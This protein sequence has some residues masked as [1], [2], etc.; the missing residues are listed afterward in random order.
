MHGAARPEQAANPPKA[1]AATAGW[2]WI[3]ARAQGETRWM[4]GIGRSDMLGRADA[5]IE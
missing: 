1:S 3:E 2:V 5:V 4:G